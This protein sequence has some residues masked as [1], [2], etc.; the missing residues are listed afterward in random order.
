MVVPNVPANKSVPKE[1]GEV[2]K[3]VEDFEKVKPK[4]KAEEDPRIKM[5][6]KKGNDIFICVECGSDFKTAAGARQHVAKKHRHRSE[7]ENEG[8]EAKKAKTE[9]YTESSFNEDVLDDWDNDEGVRQSQV[10]SLE[11]MLKK[12]DGDDQETEENET[13]VKNM[14]EATPTEKQDDE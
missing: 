11:E 14:K 4:K 3:K 13:N 12:Y 7:E 6:E 1:P 8:D 2:K 5:G 10:P 9:E